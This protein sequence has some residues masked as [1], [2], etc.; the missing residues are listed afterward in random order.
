MFCVKLV[1]DILIMMSIQIN[2]HEIM[3]KDE[4]KI[5]LRK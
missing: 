3:C 4:L 5:L 2:V 1:L